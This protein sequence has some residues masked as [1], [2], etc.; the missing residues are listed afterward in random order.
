MISVI[1][2]TFNRGFIIKTLYMSLR[3][4]TH[5]DFEWI[6]IDDG[7]ED[8][9]ACLFEEWVKNEDLFKI[10]YTYTQNGGKHRA[11]NKAVKKAQYEYCFIVDSDDYLKKNAIE[12]IHEW[13]QTIEKKVEFAGVSGLRV[14]PD[15]EIIGDYPQ[16]LSGR[17]YIDAKNLERRQ[18]HLMGDKAEV[19]KTELLLKYPF[20][21]FPGEKFLSEDVIWNKL[22]LEG[23]KIRWFNQPIYIC[24]YLK[25]GLTKDKKKEIENFI[26]FTE[27]MKLKI[28]HW[29][30]PYNYISFS[31]YYI[32]ARKKSLSDKEISNLLGLSLKKVKTIKVLSFI[33]KI[34]SKI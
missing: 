6:V 25:G 13:I 10:S 11:I 9:T 3:K 33:R 2:A 4:Q 22:S 16:L 30:F 1:T 18:Y 20:P 14:Y 12:I 17:N 8:N 21:E 24:Q 26:G 23:Y 34:T 28:Y 29:Q 5:K 32:V 15:G 7:S 31:S 19:Y 27:S